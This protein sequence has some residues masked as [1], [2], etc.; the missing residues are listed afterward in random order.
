[1][2]ES[3]DTFVWPGNIGALE[4]TPSLTPDSVRRTITIDCDRPFGPWGDVVIT[5]RGRDLRVG[6]D[7]SAEVLTDEFVRVRSDFVDDQ[8]ISEADGEPGDPGLKDLIGQQCRRGF[9]AAV[10]DK[11]APRHDDGSLL[12]AM[13]D[14]IPI[15]TSLSRASLTRRNVVSG[16]AGAPNYL[17]NRG[18]AETASIWSGAP[19]Q[20]AGWATGT[21]LTERAASGTSVHLTPGPVAPSVARA[22]E[23][24][25]WHRLDPL[26]PDGFRRWRRIDVR[27]SSVAADQVEVDAWWRDSYVDAAG[28]LRVVHEY[29]LLMQVSRA[30]GAVLASSA[31]PRVLPAP[32]C[33]RAAASAERVIGIRAADV[34]PT[35]ERTFKGETICTHLNDQLRSLSGLDHLIGSLRV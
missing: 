5:G 25:G 15:I 1:M 34:S 27:P 28:D 20:C 13:L 18:N 8:R 23:P 31:L 2:P 19:I 21:M 17:G 12:V 6:A 14:D 11:L 7:R 32:E 24:D 30:S 3:P 4:A 10:R 9:R 22:D 35:V 16:A 33:S 26:P 29:S